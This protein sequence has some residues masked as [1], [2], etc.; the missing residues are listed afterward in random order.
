MAHTSTSGNEWS[1]REDIRAIAAFVLNCTAA[2]V[3]AALLERVEYISALRQINWVFFWGFGFT[4]LIAASLGFWVQRLWRT[5]AGKWVW[6]LTTSLFALGLIAFAQRKS[7]SLQQ[8]GFLLLAWRHF[9]GAD[10]RANLNIDNC[11]GMFIFT[12]TLIRGIAY[13]LGALIAERFVPR[14]ASNT[15]P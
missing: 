11:N 3:L 13:S 5:G 1:F 4:F 15:G 9:S 10:C 12:T 8:T 14:S 7:V 2:I 6:L